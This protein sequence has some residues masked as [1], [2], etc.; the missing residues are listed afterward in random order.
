MKGAIWTDHNT[1]TTVT[2]VMNDWMP[3]FKGVTVATAVFSALI[4]EAGTKPFNSVTSEFRFCTGKTHTGH[5]RRPPNCNTERNVD[6][7]NYHPVRGETPAQTNTST[8]H[9]PEYHQIQRYRQHRNTLN[10]HHRISTTTTTTATITTSTSVTTQRPPHNDEP[11]ALLLNAATP[12][13]YT[14]YSEHFTVN[15]LQ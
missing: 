7:S 1:A 11:I 3:L 13:H 6:W 14:L 10:H 4:T 8:H 5:N 9:P 15:T 12:P 2:Y